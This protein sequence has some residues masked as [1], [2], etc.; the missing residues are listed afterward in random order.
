MTR[1]DAA[2][3]S[4]VAM[5]DRFRE[6]FYAGGFQHR[7][8]RTNRT[9]ARCSVNWFQGDFYFYGT[10]RVWYGYGSDGAVYWYDAYRITKLDTY[11]SQV[12]HRQHCT[13][14]YKGS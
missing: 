13:H 7:C 9:H 10:V 12:Q 3:Y 8:K 11:C 4:A 2:H 6:Q 1:A 14:V 5:R